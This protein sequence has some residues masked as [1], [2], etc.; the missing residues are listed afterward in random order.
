MTNPG[1]LPEEEYRELYPSS[2]GA[3]I[4]T[5]DLDRLEADLED[6]RTVDSRRSARQATARYLLG[7]TDLDPRARFA[8]AVHD[9]LDRSA[10]VRS[11]AQA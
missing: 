4:W 10:A 11:G 9:L 5:P 8:E 6:M 1:R 2:A 7:D 3:T